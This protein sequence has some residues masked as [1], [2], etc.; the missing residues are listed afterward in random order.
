MSLV[1]YQIGGLIRCVHSELRC[2]LAL[3]RLVRRER[4]FFPISARRLTGRSDEQLY[5]LNASAEVCS[6]A[7]VLNCRGVPST[8]VKP[9]IGMALDKRKADRIDKASQASLYVSARGFGVIILFLALSA[10]ATF[11]APKGRRG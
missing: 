10:F 8:A 4:I 3:F 1:V 6:D 2:W 11:K 7:T 5:F 9:F